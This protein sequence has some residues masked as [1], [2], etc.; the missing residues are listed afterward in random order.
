[1]P[2]RILSENY[3]QLDTLA[4]N[5]VSSEQAAFPVLNA[6][7]AQR[8]SKV[9]RSNGYWEITA[10]NQTLTFKETGLA[11]TLS[12]LVA[13]DE[14][15]STT[16]FLAALKAAMEAV[17]VDTFTCSVDTATKKIKIQ[18]SGTDFQIVGG[19]LAPVIG[20]TTV[21]KTG[22][23]T[24]TADELRIHTSE[25]IK[26]DFGISS[27]PDAFVLIGK[28]NS[29]INISPSAVIKLQGNATD[30][31]TAPEYEAVITYDDEIMAEFK[32]DGADGLADQ[33][34]RFW[35]LLI[36]DTQNPNGFIEIG[37]LFLGKYF[38][39]T[40]GAIQFPFSGAY[41][42][43]SNVVFSEGG[44]TYSDVRQKS[45][46]FDVTWSAL[47][48]AEKEAIDLIFAEQGISNAFFIAFDPKLAFSSRENYWT[49]FVKFESA[50]RYSLENPGFWTVSM[51][52]REEL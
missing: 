35:R 52:L 27:N 28:R 36:E 45:D 44:Q 41:I 50:P 42:D 14:Y 22:A 15:E 29:P 20:F 49:R 6:Y 11:S 43:R 7:N 10:A 19:T 13:V 32:V 9:W 40:R 25:W 31:W 23:L 3:L 8:R 26:W 1:M 47:T 18:S 51:S 16:T 5:F 34:A 4:N 12:A 21:P 17:S 46:S 38:E 33:A 48:T 2:S 37:A 30:I 24:Y 39:P